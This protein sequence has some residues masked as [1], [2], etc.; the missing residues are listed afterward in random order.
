MEEAKLTNLQRNQINYH[1]RNGDSL[2]IVEDKQDNRS[3]AGRQRCFTAN[4]RR[5]DDARKRSLDFIKQS[6]AYRIEEPIIH[7]PF[8]ETS[9]KAK[10]RLQE[11]MSGI[12]GTPKRRPT[13]K[14]NSSQEEIPDSFQRI[15]QRKKNL[16]LLPIHSQLVNLSVLAEIGERSDWLADMEELGQGKKYRS[17]IQNQ[18]AEKLREIKRLEKNQHKA[19]LEDHLEKQLDQLR[20]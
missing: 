10:K 9:E 14:I 7:G 20:V 13:K 8:R 18:I 1:L 17:M 16:V 11:D 2:P 6:G 5:R 12:K 19:D 15:Q 3:L 4:F